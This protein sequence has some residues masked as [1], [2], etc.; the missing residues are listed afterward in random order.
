[1]AR[2]T[3]D[4]PLT[5]ARV[6][7]AAVELTRL[8]GT[9]GWSIRDLAAALGSWPNSV[10]HHVGDRDAVLRLVLDRVVA[11]L[12]NPSADLSWQE[13]FRGFL[14][15]SRPVFLRY[16]GVARLLCRD[17]PT[18]PAALPIIDRGVG[19]LLRAGFGERAPRAYGVLV[20]SAFLVIALDEDRTLAGSGRDA[21]AGAM[22]AMAEPSDAGPGWQAMHGYVSQWIADA[23]THREKL[24]T[25]SVEA[26]IAGLEADLAGRHEPH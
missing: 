26:A 4:T 7:D 13:W 24:Y 25:Y 17:G 21:T 9:E 3:N 11:E 6:V 18:V 12:P 16:V 23:E 22:L 8:H 19:L 5:P 2:R 15:G 1:M 20:D 14:F 10:Y